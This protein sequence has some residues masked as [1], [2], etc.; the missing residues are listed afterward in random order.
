MPPQ[1]PKYYENIKQGIIVATYV[2]ALGLMVR[3]ADTL[4]DIKV[5]LTEHHNQINSHTEQI[6]S[7]RVAIKD[8]KKKDEEQDKEIQKLSNTVGIIQD[9]THKKNKDEDE[10]Q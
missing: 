2:F 1:K 4:I 3:I 10:W 8:G 6:T 7:I 5:I 9:R